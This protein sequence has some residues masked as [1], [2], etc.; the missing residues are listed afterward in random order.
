MC[1]TRRLMPLGI[2]GAAAKIRN[3]AACKAKGLLFSE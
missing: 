3:P 1:L 2:E